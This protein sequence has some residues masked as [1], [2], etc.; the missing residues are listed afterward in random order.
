MTSSRLA[1]R[2]RPEP[3]LEPDLPGTPATDPRPSGLTRG[4]RVCRRDL[5]AYL[6]C[7]L[8]VIPANMFS[9][10]A[11]DLHLPIGPDRVLLAAGL[12]LLVL[13]PYALRGAHLR[14]QPIHAV[15]LA[16]VGLAAWSAS[17]VGTLTTSLGFFALLDR[18][19]I[20][21]LLFALAPVLFGTAARRDL[22]LR[23]L[24]LMG[25]YL[26]VVA[27]LEMVG[28]ARL[29]FPHYI[30]DPSVGIHF[31]R[32]RGPFTEAVADGAVL[33]FCG[34]AAAAGAVRLPQSWRLVSV[35]TTGLCGLGVVLTLT[36]SIWLGT[37][38]G[39]VVLFLVTPR[40]RRF[41]I[42]V[43][44]AGAVAVV[45][46]LA[47][48]PGLRAQAQDRTQD[49]RSVWD[50]QNTDTAAVRIMEQHPLSGVGWLRFLDVGSDYVRQSPTYPVTA[51]HLEVH[52]VLLS[53]G[54]ELGLPGALLW[55]AS[56]LL[57]PVRALFRRV[58]GDLLVWQGVLVG[59][60]CVGL[61]AAMLSPLGQ[62]LP[63]LLLWI[64]AGLVLGPRHA[65]AAG[66][67]EAGTVGQDARPLLGA[68]S[69]STPA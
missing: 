45:L 52:N 63:N 17:A 56:M 10:H 30:V 53:R 19:A 25:L 23:V 62:P 38:V 65:P 29:V 21:F 37:A 12:L 2:N 13:D 69:A 36:R 15:M 31:G 67:A 18:L 8:A 44:A 47:L 41:L 5:P 34:F 54:A 60:F 20:P 7:L 22:L 57:G 40:L 4:G 58:H 61:A 28:P 32:A 55:I 16:F 64:V 1:A 26:G 6:L 24:V 48:V 14:F 49:Q 43:V 33:G 42:P 59:A 27:V 66:P 46:M 11:R 35:L 3:V 51:T 39:V 9:G 68:A 50:R